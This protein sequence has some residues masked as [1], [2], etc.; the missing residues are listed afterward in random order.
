MSRALLVNITPML[1][2]S[3]LTAASVP[4]LL[5]SVLSKCVLL[6]YVPS[7]YHSEPS[8]TDDVEPVSCGLHIMR[9]TAVA[10]NCVCVV[11]SLLDSNASA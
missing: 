11:K 2:I 10:L 5:L 7:Q 4:L 9:L 8:H 1:Y 3:L 6:L